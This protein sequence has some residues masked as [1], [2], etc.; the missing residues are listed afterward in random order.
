[1]LWRLAVLSRV[2]SFFGNRDG[3]GNGNGIIIRGN[4]LTSVQLA[5]IRFVQGF[6]RSE[7]LCQLALLAGARAKKET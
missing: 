3:V 1:V 6:M 7:Y 4:G 5:S 2:W